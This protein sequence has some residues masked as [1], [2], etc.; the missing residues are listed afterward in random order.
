MLK[1]QPVRSQAG[2]KSLFLSTC[3]IIGHLIPATALAQTQVVMQKVCQHVY[4]PAPVFE[5]ELKRKSVRRVRVMTYNVFNLFTHVGSHSRVDAENLVPN[6]SSGPQPKS[7]QDLEHIQRIIAENHSD[8][9]VLQEV[10]SKQALVQGLIAGK[11]FGK[12][13]AYLTEGNDGRGIDVGFL[14]RNDLPLTVEMRSFVQTKAF[15]PVEQ[16]QVKIF[17]RD[18]PMLILRNA[19][20]NEVILIV[21]GVHAKS[22]RDRPGDPKSSQLR[23]LQFQTKAEIVD[24]LKSEFGD[25]APIVVAGDFNTDVQNSRDHAPLKK[26]MKSAF[27]VAQMATPQSERI[28]HTYHPKDQNGVDLPTEMSQLDE[29][30]V[31]PSLAERVREA[32]V[33]R[34]VHPTT[35]RPLPFA[36][37]YADRKKQPSDHL[38]VLIELDLPF[39]V[40]SGRSESSHQSGQ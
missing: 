1:L 26:S 31:S 11:N 39:S 36:Q 17:S 6:A 13:K 18:F 16:R 38:P 19:D 14:V 23:Q 20:T 24:L 25:Q 34:Y 29:I 2:Y 32:K 3:L 35:R 9:V 33:V 28:T 7:R 8:I 12:Y 10:E 40:S 5:P 21:A 4:A 15:D 37:T 30:L 27:D 22:Q